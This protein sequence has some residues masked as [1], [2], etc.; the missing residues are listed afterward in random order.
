MVVYR[1]VTF[2]NRIIHSRAMNT[3]IL[4]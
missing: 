1:K 2:A 4:H 3:Y